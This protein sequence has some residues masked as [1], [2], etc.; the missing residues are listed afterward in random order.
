MARGP[1]A[2][3][4]DEG[5]LIVAWYVVDDRLATQSRVVSMGLQ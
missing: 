3:I 5:I 2:G 1:Y 4:Q